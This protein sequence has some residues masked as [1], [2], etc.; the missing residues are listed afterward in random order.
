MRRV[1]RDMKRM[2]RNG[3][4]TGVDRSMK[5]KSFKA[6]GD[7]YVRGGVY[8]YENFESEKVLPVKSGNQE[9]YTRISFVR[10]NSNFSTLS[11]GRKAKL[12]LFVTFVDKDVTRTVSVA[13][14][15]NAFRLRENTATWQN[16]LLGDIIFI[17]DVTFGS[18]TLTVGNDQKNQW[19]E[20]DIT[21]LIVDGE[22]VLALSIEGEGPFHGSN[23]VEFASRETLNG[24]EI[25]F[26]EFDVAPTP[27]PMGQCTKVWEP[28]ILRDDQ[29]QE[30][31]DF[32]EGG[33]DYKDEKWKAMLADA[34]EQCLAEIIA[35]S[36][37]VTVIDFPNSKFTYVNVAIT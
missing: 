27:A 24:P 9:D 12:R 36:M 23:L 35:E 15:P 11:R 21:D 32:I 1:G 13:R 29:I 14:M 16:T 4:K 22:M 7:T 18:S 20:V 6:V 5:H 33:C 8:S 3:K 26:E 19:V 31:I 37:A 25:I 10:F 30:A 28:K 34:H 2:K 17:E